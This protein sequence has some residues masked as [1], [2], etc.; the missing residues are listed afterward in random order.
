MALLIANFQP[1]GG[2]SKAGNAP[3]LFSYKSSGDNLA[4][5]KGSGYFDGVNEALNAGDVIMFI[6]V[7]G[8]ADFITVAAV[9]DGVVTIES[10]DINSA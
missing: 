7:G 6:D 4:T 8:A 5:V 9:T 10:T 2:Q 1:I 3:Q